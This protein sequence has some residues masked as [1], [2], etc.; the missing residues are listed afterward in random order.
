MEDLDSEKS[1]L[2]ISL[3][4]SVTSSQFPLQRSKRSFDRRATRSGM[5][6]CDAIMETKMELTT[7][8]IE[9]CDRKEEKKPV[10][11]EKRRQDIQ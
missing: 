6:S 4:I 2:E 10:G 7:G 5:A 11:R 9:L 1:S 3:T 8:N